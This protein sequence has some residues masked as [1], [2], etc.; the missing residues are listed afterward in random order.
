MLLA[1]LLTTTEGQQIA[2]EPATNS[3]TA[4]DVL[5]LPD[6]TMVKHA[7]AANARLRKNYPQGFALDAT[8]HPH[9]TLLQRYVRTKDLDAVYAA[10]QKVLNREH[11]A[12]WELEATG[13][14]FLN[15]NNMGLA[16]IIIE[17]T[18]KLL[19]LQQA[20]IEAVTPYTEPKGTAAAYVTTP[21]HPDINAPTLQYVNTF[22]PERIGK[23]Y[24]PH[25]TIGVGQLDFVQKMKA[26]PFEHFHF[27]VAGA[28]IF[29]LGNYGTAQKRLWVWKVQG[30][31]SK[32]YQKS[33]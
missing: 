13:Y 8:H 30:K 23:N 22:I 24:N 19:R 7:Q 33:D 5:L 15:F 20:I 14:Y 18:P 21:E 31:N 26:A 6:Q 2:A 11:P 27:K 32:R 16:G 10:V 3:L 12:G 9:I 28:A 4:I 29:H 25:V 1:A 17:P